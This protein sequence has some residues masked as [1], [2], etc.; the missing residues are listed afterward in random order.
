MRIE[1]TAL[2]DSL[3]VG[4][5]SGLF[6]S[7]F[8]QRFRHIMQADLEAE[9][10]VSVFAKS[11]LET[12]EILHLLSLP[13]VQKRIQTADMITITGCGNDLFE[14]VRAFQENPDETIFRRASEHCHENFE[15]MI[16]QIARIKW[17]NAPPYAIRVFNLYNPFPD[18]PIADKWITS[19]NSHLSQLASAP[20]VKIADVYSAFKGKEKEYLSFDGVHPNSQGYQVMADTL[21]KIGYGEIAH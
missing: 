13:Y 19:Y 8:V 4:R 6:S 9:V 5:G 17:K 20:H 21:Q 10:S 14:S 18:I 3:T 16:T 12:E 2:G 15:K 1:Y 11:G 7:G